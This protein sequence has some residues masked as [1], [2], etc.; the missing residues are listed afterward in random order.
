MTAP[1]PLR[2]RPLEADAAT[3]LE[4]LGPEPRHLLET[5]TAAKS[6]VLL[7]VSDNAA[8]QSFAGAGDSRQQRRGRRVDVNPDG[9]DAILDH[10]IERTRKFVFAEIVLILADADRLG[11]NLDQFGQRVL[12]PPRS[13]L[14]RVRT[15]LALATPVRQ[16]PKRSRP[17]PRPPRQ[18]PWSTRARDGAE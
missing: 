10:R 1:S 18:P 6:T 15:R 13:R 7:T 17:T 12:K 5:R 4:S 11:I 3:E 8:R 9:V 2:K 16:K 14:L